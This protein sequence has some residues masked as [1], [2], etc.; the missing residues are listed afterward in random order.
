ML[1]VEVESHDNELSPSSDRPTLV[2]AWHFTTGRLALVELRT[3]KNCEKKGLEDA[4]TLAVLSKRMT[5]TANH[6]SI[7]IPA[8][9]WPWEA[10]IAM[11]HRRELTRNRCFFKN[12]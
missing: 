11:I 2:A 8:E 7:S 6:V 3:D 4:L 1:A 10:P 9:S 12:I 5:R